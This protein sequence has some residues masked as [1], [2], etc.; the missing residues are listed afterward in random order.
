ML[1]GLRILAMCFP[2]LW[3]NLLS[4]DISHQVIVPG[5][6]LAGNSKMY[7]SQTV[8]EVM[9]QTV[10]NSIYTLTQ[11]F[12][13]PPYVFKIIPD[14]IYGIKV[15]PNPVTDYVTIDM[16]GDKAGT[17]R[18]DFLDLMGRTVISASKTF[19]RNYEYH[20]QY[21]VGELP[22]GFY[23]VRIMSGDGLTNRVFRIQKI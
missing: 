18:I 13:Q 20:E 2:V 9:V 6:V 14:T 19:G 10:T 16:K 3:T 23:M 7:L 11:G 17:Y 21:N 5:A 1:K 12:Q 15:Y 4:Q 8:G 22:G